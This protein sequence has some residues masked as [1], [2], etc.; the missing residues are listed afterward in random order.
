MLIEGN[1]LSAVLT[2]VPQD[3]DQRLRCELRV[4][5]FELRKSV[6]EPK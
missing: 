2:V 4:D 1:A 6:A 3:H 5:T